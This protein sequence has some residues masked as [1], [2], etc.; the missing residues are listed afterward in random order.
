MIELYPLSPFLPGISY[1]FKIRGFYPLT[2][3]DNIYPLIDF[4]FDLIFA[5]DIHRF[6]YFTCWHINVIPVISDLNFIPANHE[7]GR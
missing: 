4:T 3:L 1:K 5:G 6:I 2:V 7:L